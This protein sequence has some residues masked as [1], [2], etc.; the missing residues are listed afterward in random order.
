MG[1]KNTSGSLGNPEIVFDFDD[2]L[3]S[4]SALYVRVALECTLLIVRALG[5]HTF[6]AEEILAL[7]KEIDFGLMK[8]MGFTNTCRYAAG[9]VRIYEAL[10]DRAGLSSEPEVVR[11]LSEMAGRVWTQ[12]YMPVPGAIEVLEELC[13]SGYRPWLLTVGKDGAQRRKVES[14]GLGRFFEPERIIAVEGRKGDVLACLA[15]RDR[16]VVMVGNSLKSDILEA[17]RVGQ[18][19]IHVPCSIEWEF[20]R[21]DMSQLPPYWRVSTIREVPDILRRI[22]LGEQPSSS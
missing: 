12:P 16:L 11:Q 15:E 1:R 18:Q 6:S 2:T 5:W 13:S 8:T 4:T 7:H 17:L 14:S 22:A 3:S 9:W 20:D 10:C 21:A 19:A